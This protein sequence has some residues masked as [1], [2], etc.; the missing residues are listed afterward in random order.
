M[1]GI[2]AREASKDYLRVSSALL[3]GSGKLDH[4]V[5]LLPNQPPA[6]RTLDNLRQ[7]F[8]LLLLAF[9]WQIEFLLLNVPNPRH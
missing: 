2:V 4:R 3:E 5:I 6:N 7:V 8:K 9:F 1:L